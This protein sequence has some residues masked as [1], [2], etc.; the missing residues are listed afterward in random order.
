MQQMINP[1]KNNWGS[2]SDGSKWVFN[3]ISSSKGL[4]Q[5]GGKKI[6]FELPAE[7]ELGS[8]RIDIADI[9][10]GSDADKIILYEFKL[11]QR[12]FNSTYA[13]QF[14]KDLNSVDKLSQ[15]KWLYDGSK[16]SSL[17][18]ADYIN[19][20]K[21][22]IAFNSQKVRTVFSKY[23]EGLGLPPIL[24]PTQ[25]ENFLN[26]NNSWFTEIFKVIK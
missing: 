6:K 19:L 18:I 15:I 5:F 9:T 7:T 12:P 8:R 22:N 17:N 23:A 21:T 11:V 2:F 20:L 10:N 1:L 24:N 13:T 4:T 3:Y 25:L 16:V 26:S 14:V